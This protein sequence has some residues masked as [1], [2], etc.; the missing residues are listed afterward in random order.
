[1]K[2][3]I[4]ALSIFT[5]IMSA[6]IIS[7]HN[8]SEKVEDLEKN[9]K[10]ANENL[11][12]ANKEYLEDVKNYRKETADKIAANDLAISEFKT[13]LKHEKKEIKSDVKKRIAELEQKNNDMKAKM[14]GYSEGGKEKWEAFKVEF[15]HD[16]DELG[17]AFSDLTVKNVK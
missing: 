3:S 9:L 11:E 1:M 8:S 15:T 16:M 5:F 17:K 4:L 2:R 7:C 13:R 10:E 14:D 6:S 12:K